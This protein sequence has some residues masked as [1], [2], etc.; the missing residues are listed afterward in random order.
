MRSICTR[1]RNNM[2]K[3][4][5][6]LN[7]IYV[8]LFWALVLN[9]VK[10]QGN[11]PKVFLG[12]FFAVAFLVFICHLLYYIPLPK[13]YIYADSIY[14][15]THLLVFPLYY[16]YIRLLSVDHESSIKRH[17][18]Y[19]IAP[20]ALSIFYTIGVFFMNPTEHIAFVY[21]HT[22]EGEGAK[23]IFYYQK[24]VSL[25]I[26]V[27]FFVQGI[28]YM[29][30]SILSVRQNKERFVIFYS[31][32]EE[33]L[34]RKVQWLNVTVSV[35]MSTSIIME[36]LGKTAFTG[37][38]FFL[39]APSIIFTVMLFCIGWLGN[40]QTEVL[41][42]EIPDVEDTVDEDITHTYLTAVATRHAAVLQEIDKLFNIHQIYLDNHLS[43]LDLSKMTG[44]NRTYVSKVINSDFGMNFSVFVNSFRMAH[45]R[46]MLADNPDIP[47]A[48]LAE[49]SGFGSIRTMQRVMGNTKC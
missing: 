49:K 46:K 13:I 32:D 35:T 5:L 19:I 30:L 41:M 22:I 40:S 15:L 25:V 8:T 3:L 16:V 12:K 38:D 48:E 20:F 45:A 47:P 23:A 21:N 17:Y 18:K 27:A 24:I 29:T 39:L 7:P 6:L 14:Y 43:I 2:Y 36:V 11:E 9:T 33:H 10:Q 28:V 42:K 44:S 4:F 31:N 26:R 1:L 34:L 37:N